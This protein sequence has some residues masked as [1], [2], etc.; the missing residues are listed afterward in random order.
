M[1]TMNSISSLDKRKTYG[2]SAYVYVTAITLLA[3][4]SSGILLWQKNTAEA[5]DIRNT[6]VKITE[7]KLSVFQAYVKKSLEKYDYI[8][9]DLRNRKHTG[10][11]DNELKRLHAL[12][13]KIMDMLYMNRDGV[14]VNWTGEGAAP[15]A[16]DREFYTELRD[17]PSMT[18]YI[19]AVKRS[20]ARDGK[21]FFSI[22]RP[23]E[24]QFGSFDGVT[25]VLV[26][27][28]SLNGDLEKQLVLGDYS[29]AILKENGKTLMRVPIPAAGID[30]TVRKMPAKPASG[31]DMIFHSEALSPYDNKV[32]LVAWQYLPEYQ[33]WAVVT[34]PK[35][36]VEKAL[37]SNL[38]N[39]LI[40]SFFV[41]AFLGLAAALVVMHLKRTRK[42]FNALER[43]KSELTVQAQT[44]ALTG[45][46]NR[47]FFYKC[48]ELEISRMQRYG[49]SIAIA[50]IDVDNFKRINDEFGH[51]IGDS[52]LAALAACLDQGKRQTDFVA[53]YGGEEFVMLFSH[54][55]CQQAG[56]YAELIRQR[57]EQLHIE[58]TEECPVPVTISIGFSMILSNENTIESALHR[59]DVALYKSKTG[60]KNRVSLGK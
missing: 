36:N 21:W 5:E 60:G 12:D 47:R 34:K 52:V 41:Y 9:K 54:T 6:A 26:T 24:D 53:R 45:L 55:S 57:V 31:S 29:L 58:K 22:S 48:A 18:R 50:L 30:Q 56:K 59:A 37:R 13:P 38:S 1:N 43:E 32:R 2:I 44:D 16:A 51:Q 23:L 35:D 20:R 49:G 42:E 17:N 39:N 7:A 4:V 33:L 28:E 25:V 46:Y 27:V 19:S 15:K 10:N 3:C 11:I 40:L 14:T 8:A